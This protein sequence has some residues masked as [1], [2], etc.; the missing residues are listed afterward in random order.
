MA[1]HLTHPGHLLALLD[2]ALVDPDQGQPAE[3]R[4]RVE[5]GHQRLQR[6]L[7]IALRRRNVLEQH[8]EQR[9]QVL[10]VGVLAV[11]RLGGAGDARATRG[12]QRRQAE[13]VFSSRLRFGVQVG[14]DVE[15]QVVALGHHL[16]DTRVGT[17]GLVDHKDHRQVCGQRLAQHE[18]GLR[19][20]AFGGIDEQQH[21]VDHRQP[22]LDFAAEVG[23]PGRVDDVDDGHRAVRVLA[24]HGG[25]L[26]QDRDAL[27]LLQVTRVH[28]AFDDVV[29]AMSQR[30]RL[31]QHRIHQGRLAV[32]DVSDDGDVSEIHV[33]DCFSAGRLSRN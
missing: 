3:E 1:V 20:R 9:V 30:P 5:V 13:R 19:Q 25:V 8:V 23:V 31:P 11:G 15:Q 18:P 32:I 10:A 17:V 4:R 29:A 12:V 28:Q 26:R 27:F 24:V 6:G 22:A 14:G 2:A 21:P 33:G 7:G 16:G